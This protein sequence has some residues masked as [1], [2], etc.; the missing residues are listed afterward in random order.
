MK[1]APMLWAIRGGRTGDAD[2]LFLE[3]NRIALGWEKLSDLSKLKP[4]R[5]T[6]K[7]VVAAAWPEKSNGGIANNAGQLFRFVHEMKPRDLVIYPSKIDRKLH[8]GR[9]VGPYHYDPVT[10]PRYPHSRTAEWIGA[11]P[12]AMFSQGALYEVN[13]PTT[14]FTVKQYAEEFVAALEGKTRSAGEQ[15]ESDETVSVVFAEIEQ[16]T[17]NF[18]LKRLLQELKGHPFEQFVAHVLEKMGYRTRVS[19]EGADGGVDII[20]HKDEL[21]LEPPIIK[22]QVKAVESSIGDPMV[23][24]LVGKV[25]HGEFGLFVTLSTFTLQA[26][27]FASA[28]TNLRLIDGEEFVDL[29]LAHYE[30]FDSRYK[31]IIP[32]KRV[33]VPESLNESDE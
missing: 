29:V 28:N 9:V 14:F 8:I 17:R 5:E 27:Q 13:I 1:D 33:Y 25:R 21:G 12:R 24:A 15:T 11:F 10:D 3:G 7:K 2:K 6:F 30:Q 26:K 19:P 32:L 4:D 22:V 31:A 20:A 16:T 23:S 18:V